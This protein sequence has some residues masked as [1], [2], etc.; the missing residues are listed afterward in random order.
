[1]EKGLANFLFVAAG[2]RGWNYMYGTCENIEES[3][4]GIETSI[5]S[6]LM[7]ILEF[8]S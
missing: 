8:T 5:T 4:I 1:M 6:R 3:T 7:G 2:K